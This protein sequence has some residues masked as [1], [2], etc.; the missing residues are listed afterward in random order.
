[1]VTI[2]RYCEENDWEQHFVDA[3]YL[4]LSWVI[5]CQQAFTKCPSICAIAINFMWI[6]WNF[7]VSFCTGPFLISCSQSPASW[8][9]DNMFYM[10]SDYN[11]R[12]WILSYLKTTGLWSDCT[13]LTELSFFSCSTVWVHFH[14]K[15][16]AHASDWRIIRSWSGSFHLIWRNQIKC[17]NHLLIEFVKNWWSKVKL[18][19]KQTKVKLEQC[20]V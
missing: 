7:E 20:T 12:N 17:S 2:W 8:A 15:F 5:Q 3:V 10:D 13:F 6:R 4:I 19:V 16:V 18:N 1:M 14:K 11:I 9:H